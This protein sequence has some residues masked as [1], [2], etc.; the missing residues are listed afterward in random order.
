MYED[1]SQP[2]IAT[3]LDPRYKK[4]GF[5]ESANADATVKHLQGIV[6]GVMK[7]QKNEKPKDVGKPAPTVRSHRNILGFL[8][9]DDVEE[10]RSNSYAG[11]AILLVEKYLKMKRVDQ[12]SDPLSFWF[13]NRACF[14]ELVP[15]VLEHLAIPGSSVPCERMFSREGY[16]VT[17]R[18]NR[19]SAKN[20]QMLT[21][22]NLNYPL[23]DRYYEKLDFM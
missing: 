15:I 1:R 13:E 20:V 23:V 16:I 7:A 2:R 21:V 14:P 12:K 4:K 5:R 18:R 17:A 3:L 10:S 11:E 22:L 9:E 8:N 6:V 19:L